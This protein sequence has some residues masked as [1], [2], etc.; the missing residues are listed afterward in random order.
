[1]RTL[2]VL[3][4][5]TLARAFTPLVLQKRLSWTMTP[6]WATNGDFPEEED[7]A[8]TGTTDWDAEWKKVMANQAQPI[9]RPGKD[10]YKS[11]AEIAAIRAANEAASKASRLTSSLPSWQQLQ[12]DWRFWISVLAVVSVGASILS[13]GSSSSMVDP[14][15]NASP[16]SYFI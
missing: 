11:E 6:R 9:E 4:T 14:V 7:F 2:L 12:G 3:C 10:F 1:M 5:L 15:T 8:Y 13:A 16:G